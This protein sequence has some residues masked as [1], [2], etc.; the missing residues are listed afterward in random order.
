METKAQKKQVTFNTSAAPI[1]ISSSSNERNKIKI[2]P[3][4]KRI[5]V[6]SFNMGNAIIAPRQRTYTV[7]EYLESE[8]RYEN[9]K[10]NISQRH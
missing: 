4:Q 7:D 6:P 8:R 2:S 3:Y 10:K 9:T 1:R 5:P